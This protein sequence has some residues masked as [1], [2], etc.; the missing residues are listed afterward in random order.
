M[1]TLPELK[2]M[3]KNIDLTKSTGKIDFICLYL[4]TQTRMMDVRK[5]FKVYTLT[6]LG[7]NNY[8]D[9]KKYGYIFVRRLVRNAMRPHLFISEHDIDRIFTYCFKQV[10]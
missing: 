6:D 1:T 4:D 2:N 5:K 8:N 7:F 10:S 3:I 9:G